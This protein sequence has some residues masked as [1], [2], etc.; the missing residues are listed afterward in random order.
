MS[1]YFTDWLL[2]SGWLRIGVYKSIK[3]TKHHIASRWGEH[4]Q[5]NW[6]GG[7]SATQRP[8]LMMIIFFPDT[9]AGRHVALHK[10]THKHTR[11]QPLCTSGGWISSIEWRNLFTQLSDSA[12]DELVLSLFVAAKKWCWLATRSTYIVGNTVYVGK[13]A[14]KV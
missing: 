14:C 7:A 11:P 6:C 5:R 8:C 12:R 9:W 13:R 2:H 4:T 10:Y 1:H 3:S